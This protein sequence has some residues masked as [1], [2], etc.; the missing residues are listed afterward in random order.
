MENAVAE[1]GVDAAGVAGVEHARDERRC[2]RAGDHER[3]RDNHGD[4]ESL[5]FPPFDRFYGLESRSRQFA[6]LA[7]R[8]GG[9]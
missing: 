7:L 3:R 2:R 1:R 8:F 9:T 4:D 6:I 5:H